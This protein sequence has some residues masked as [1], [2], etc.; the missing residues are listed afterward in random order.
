MKS[1]TLREK[2]MRHNSWLHLQDRRE[3]AD[4]VLR[5][6]RED[7]RKHCAECLRVKLAIEKQI[8]KNQE[9]K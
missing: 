2:I 4:Y 6:I 9:D 5:L 1:K 8:K 7:R 3:L